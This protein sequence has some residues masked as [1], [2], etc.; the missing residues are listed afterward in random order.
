MRTEELTSFEQAVGEFWSEIL[1]KDG[2]GIHDDFFDLG[3]TSQQLIHVVSKMGER[4]SLPLDT[5]IVLEGVTIASLAKSVQRRAG[6]DWQVASN[7]N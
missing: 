4:F 2:I 7:T 3:G 6:G 1:K 5:N